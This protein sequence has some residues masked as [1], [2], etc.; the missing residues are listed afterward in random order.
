MHVC[1]FLMALLYQIII[2]SQVFLVFYL[3]SSTFY[4]FFM[5]KL[6]QLLYK[7][8]SLSVFSRDILCQKITDVYI[9]CRIMLPLVGFGFQPIMPSARNHCDAVRP[10]STQFFPSG[11]LTFQKKCAK[12]CLQRQRRRHAFPERF[13]ERGLYA[14][15]A[16]YSCRK[17]YHFRAVSAEMPYRVRP[18]TRQ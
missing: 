14:E 15:M 10:L 8:S 18:L 5:H 16:L 13:P 7:I 11:G 9:R 4:I 1:M 3:V 6:C 2:K 12:F 17:R